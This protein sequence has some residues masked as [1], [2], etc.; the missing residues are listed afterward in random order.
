MEF[1]C[2]VLGVIHVLIRIR[3]HEAKFGRS[4]EE[5]GDKRSPVNLISAPL[6]PNRIAAFPPNL[7]LDIPSHI[8]LFAF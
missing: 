3:H 1:F 2:L 5:L 6:N 4:A 8:I 7:I